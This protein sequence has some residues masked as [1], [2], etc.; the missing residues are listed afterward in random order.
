MLLLVEHLQ[1]K[2]LWICPKTLLNVDYIIPEHRLFKLIEK[3]LTRYLGDFVVQEVA[4]GF[5]IWG[6]KKFTPPLANYY[7]GIPPYFLNFYG[8]LWNN[9]GEHS[10][11][12]KLGE[13]FGVDGEELLMFYLENKFNLNIRK[14]ENEDT[15]FINE[16]K[17][18]SPIL[19]RRVYYIK[20]LVT[21]IMNDGGVVEC[22]FENA[23]EYKNWV[24]DELMYYM[25][26][27]EEAQFLNKIPPSELKMFWDNHISKEIISRWNFICGE[28]D[29]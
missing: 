2:I 20:K 11:H 8:V 22:E 17:K 26:V 24:W 16:S 9:L 6:T 28:Q 15:T 1:I 4:D 7:L 18:I 3:I 29:I 21:T 14:F 25:E 23:N 5:N 10:P 19:R 13:L 12:H 27:Y